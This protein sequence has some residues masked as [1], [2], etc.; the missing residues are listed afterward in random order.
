MA[1]IATNRQGAGMEPAK[2]SP[3]SSRAIVVAGVAFLL[4][5]VAWIP[6][7][8]W[9]SSLT[10]GNELALGIMTAVFWLLVFGVVVA[11]VAWSR[12]AFERWD[13]RDLMLVAVVGAAFGPL[14]ALWTNIYTFAGGF[15][16]PWNDLVGGFWWLPAILV[17]Y[18]IRK[19]GA[20]LVAETLA[21][22]V[23]VL[24]GSP[25]GFVGAALAGL[26]QGMGAEVVFMLTGWK[27]YDWLTLSLAG[28]AS[29]VTG[30]VYLWP[31][32]YVGYSTQLL[33][34]TL[35]AYIIGVLIFAVVGGK[36]LGDALLSTGVLNRFAIGRERRQA[37]A[38]G[39]F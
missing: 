21:A 15:L 13:T 9:F 33:L 19:P 8:N 31:I 12:A 22:L 18:I 17:P 11:A 38:S 7:Y 3:V 16:G 20:A 29:A 23:S 35:A 6:L 4:L 2:P 26:T 39:E 34:I 5:F 14:F 1:E 30:F 25:Y 10:G 27:R 24:A 28:V 36:L 37:A 32:Y